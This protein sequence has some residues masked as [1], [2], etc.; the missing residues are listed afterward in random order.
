LILTLRLEKAPSSPLRNGTRSD[1]ERFHVVNEQRPDE[2]RIVKSTNAARQAVTGHNVRIVLA[3][4]V[5]AA[6]I[7]LGVA[8]I[9]V[10]GH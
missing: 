8:W 5:V 3:I 4:S 9:N 10:A 2:A 1:A 6:I 7:A